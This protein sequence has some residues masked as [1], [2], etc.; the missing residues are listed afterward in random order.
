MNTSFDIDDISL[1]PRNKKTL[2]NFLK[3]VSAGTSIKVQ[4][5]YRKVD[6]DSLAKAQKIASLTAKYLNE[7]K[8]GAKVIQEISESVDITSGIKVTLTGQ[9]FPQVI[10]LRK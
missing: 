6:K 4:A 10:Y 1:L 8:L 2:D 3:T 7:Q 9:K 5:T